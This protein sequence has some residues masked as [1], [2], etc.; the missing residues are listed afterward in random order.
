MNEKSNTKYQIFCDLDGVL[1]DLLRGVN[2]TLY[3]TPDPLRSS[4]HRKIQAE[5]QQALGHLPLKQENLNKNSEYFL[6]PVREFMYRVARDDRKFWRNLNW[7]DGGNEL[8]SFIRK[9]DPIILSR[10][11]DLQAVIGKKNWVKDNLGLKG[12][13]VQIRYDKTP[14]AKYEGK[15]GVLIDD[16]YKNTEAFRSAGGESILY[17]NTNQAIESLKALGFTG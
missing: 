12:D 1:V 4:R 17:K 6:K 7:L 9:Y 16:F 14:Y 15:I 11:T 5:A 2:D 10:P 8:W 13:R 3:A